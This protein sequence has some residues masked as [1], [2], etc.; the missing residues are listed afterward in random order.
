ME[1]SPDRAVSVVDLLQNSFAEPDQIIKSLPAE[2]HP[3]YYRA[4]DF[5][6]GP[7]KDKALQSILTP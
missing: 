2:E 4:L 7:E 6:T 1:L 3:R 5:H